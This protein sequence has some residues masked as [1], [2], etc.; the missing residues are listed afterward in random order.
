MLRNALE[1]LAS[2]LFN[3]DF[4]RLHNLEIT[5]KVGIDHWLILLLV[6]VSFLW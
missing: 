4:D 5:L 1:S 2:V 6:I 3:H